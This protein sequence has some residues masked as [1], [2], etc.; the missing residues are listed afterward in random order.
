MNK[1]TNMILEGFIGLR[2][3]EKQPCFLEGQQD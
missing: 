2:K 3:T 1:T